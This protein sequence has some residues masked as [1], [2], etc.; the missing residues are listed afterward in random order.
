MCVFIFDLTN[1]H[2]LLKKYNEPC[3]CTHVHACACTHVHA[4][5]CTHVHACACTH[6]HA[7]VSN[8][9]P[10]VYEPDV[11][12]LLLCVNSIKAII[13]TALQCI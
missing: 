2:T 4:C 1:V 11:V 12:Y 8:N 13:I 5:A 3:V 6:V 9:P 10:S 7:C